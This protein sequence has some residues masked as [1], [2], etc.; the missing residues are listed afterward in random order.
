MVSEEDEGT[1][2]VNVGKGFYKSIQELWSWV[3]IFSF[4]S[5]NL[6][7]KSSCCNETLMCF[8]IGDSSGSTEPVTRLQK[9]VQDIFIFPEESATIG[10]GQK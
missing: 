2:D 1:N 5:L 4:A 9:T 3:S 10:K 7:K 8:E 6:P